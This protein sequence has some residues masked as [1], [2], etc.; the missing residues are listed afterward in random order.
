MLIIDNNESII[1][2]INRITYLERRLCDDIFLKEKNEIELLIKTD[3][4]LLLNYSKLKLLK[5]SVQ[6]VKIVIN[7]IW[8]IE[9]IDILNN[10]EELHI[11]HNILRKKYYVFLAIKF[12]FQEIKKFLKEKKKYTIIPLI[13]ISITISWY[14]LIT[15][16]VHS[17]ES[18]IDSIQYLY[19][20][21]ILSE[22]N[23]TKL[24][25]RPL[26]VFTENQTSFSPNHM[27][28]SG[29]NRAIWNVI[30]KNNASHSI[31]LVQKTRLKDSEWKIFRTIDTISIP[32]G[33]KDSDW[34][35]IP[36]MRNTTVI[37]DTFDENWEFIGERWN[38]KEATTL[39]LVKENNFN[40]DI[41]TNSD[42]YGG[43]DN[44]ALYLDERDEDNIE[45]IF[46]QEIKNKAVFEANKIL[47]ERW[48][49]LFMLT[50]PE[51]YAFKEYQT[52]TSEMQ[53]G[54]IKI[55]G[56]I[57]AKVHYIDTKQIEKQMLWDNEYINKTVKIKDIKILEK[58][59]LNLHIFFELQYKE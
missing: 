1:D 25:L 12:Y 45:K 47:Q 43:E 13:I 31:T 48:K 56:N 38:I 53:D 18:N 37:A 3:N 59:P 23:N 32:K 17:N 10:L 28:F 22:E 21:Y 16:Y 49:N 57:K 55:N 19:K 15:Q 7:L 54:N 33:I 6:K 41:I 40:I 34:N 4:S 26:V 2:I 44:Y 52:S 36:G 27:D 11:K 42:F 46:E 50:H 29:T 14:Y 30:F 58:D 8:A 5:E 24:K 35:I 9:N 51:T 39:H 20:D